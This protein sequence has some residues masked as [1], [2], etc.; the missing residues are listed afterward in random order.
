[1]SGLLG[2][3]QHK[4]AQSNLLRAQAGQRSDMIAAEIARDEAMRD[5]AGREAGGT[6]VGAVAPMAYQYAK[7]NNIMGLGAGNK[8]LGSADYAKMKASVDALPADKLGNETRALFNSEYSEM[9]NA[10]KFGQWVDKSLND[11]TQTLTGTQAPA[12]VSANSPVADG[13]VKLQNGPAATTTPLTP[14][15]GLGGEQ[16]LVNA[17]DIPSDVPLDAVQSKAGGA[18][19]SGMGDSAVKEVT[20]VDSMV[21]SGIKPNSAQMAEVPVHPGEVTIDSPV[22]SFA[23]SDIG[24]AVQGPPDLT[25][26]GA[27]ATKEAVNAGA[28]PITTAAANEAAK[29]AVGETTKAAAGEVTAKVGTT[30]ANEATKQI[31]QEVGKEVTSSAAQNLASTA[32]ANGVKSVATSAT[33]SVASGAASMGVGLAAGLAGGAIGEAVGGKTGGKIGS[34]LASAAAAGMMLGPWGAVAAVAIAGI[35]E[36]F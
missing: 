16:H 8:M 19:E 14:E 10:D 20:P 5:A 4:K 22:N 29:T 32:A 2:R 7:D 26:L 31:T 18:W 9:T 30:V 35:M 6:V 25:G 21:Q 15:A 13:A 36:L 1:M 28:K 33:S 12:P 34:T 27:E 24:G 23:N 3:G 17:S 11:T